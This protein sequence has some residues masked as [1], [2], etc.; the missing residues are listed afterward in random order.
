VVRPGTLFEGTL[1]PAVEHVLI[2]ELQAR[3]LL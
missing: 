2:P 1:A 3:G